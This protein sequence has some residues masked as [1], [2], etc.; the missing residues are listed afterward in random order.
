MIALGKTLDDNL[1]KPYFVRMAMWQFHVIFVK[2]YDGSF[3][4]YSIEDTTPYL[5]L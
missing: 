3:V 1:A 2:C 4:R 5:F